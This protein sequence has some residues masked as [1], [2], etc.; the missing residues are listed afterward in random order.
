[1]LYLEP[2]RAMVKE[3][4]G[5]I[6]PDRSLILLIDFKTEPAQTYP[7]LERELEPYHDM[8]THWEGNREF[9]G[10]ITVLLT[11]SRPRAEVT[12]QATRWVALDGLATDL[13]KNPPVA[14][15]PLVSE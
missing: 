15:V 13:E 9:P 2:L 3:R 8:L 14:L 5:R 4:G 6:Y 1:S 7:E 11:G 12:A 10:A